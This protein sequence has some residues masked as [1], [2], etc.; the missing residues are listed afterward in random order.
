MHILSFDLLE[1]VSYDVL[2]GKKNWYE[3]RSKTLK[4]KVGICFPIY[5]KV[6]SHFAMNS[7]FLEFSKQ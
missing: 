7:F 2:I 3:H 6:Y 5:S 4:T 1:C